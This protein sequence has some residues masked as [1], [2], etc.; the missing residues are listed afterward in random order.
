M[1]LVTVLLTV[2]CL[3]AVAP[4][5]PSSLGSAG[6]VAE[7]DAEVAPRV[8]GAPPGAGVGPRGGAARPRVDPAV[9]LDLAA[10]GLDAGASIPGALVALGDALDDAGTAGADG[11]ALR[12]AAASLM[13][14]SSWEEAWV[15]TPGRLRALGDALEPA[16]VDGVAAGP[17]LTSAADRLRAGVAR[18]AEEAAARLGVRLVVPLGLCFLPSFVLL[19]LVP[20]VLSAGAGLFG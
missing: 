10:A 18:S 14:G 11:E 5:W 1:I 2:L 17:L 12:R 19:G 15:G 4:W 3:L 9:V 20:V 16:W 7:R 8:R 6:R 13:L